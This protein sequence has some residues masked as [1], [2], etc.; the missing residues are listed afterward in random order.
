MIDVSKILFEICE[1]EKVFDKN[2][3][4]ID[5]GVLDSYSFIS[6]FA[7]LED[8]GILIYPTQIN[9]ELLRTSGSIQKIVDEYLKKQG[10]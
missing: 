7:E 8:L 9:R 3:D 5:S 10:K 6:L 2:F 1:D 4:L